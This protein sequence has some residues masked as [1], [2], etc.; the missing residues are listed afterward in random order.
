MEARKEELN[1][2]LLAV[3]TEKQRQ[4][5]K[6]ML[7]EPFKFAQPGFGGPGGPGG[8]RGPGGPGGPGG[9]GQ[10]GGGRRGGGGGGGQ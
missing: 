7:G 5:W 8:Q 2:K 10:G 6:Q 9:G 1:K 3:L 4:T